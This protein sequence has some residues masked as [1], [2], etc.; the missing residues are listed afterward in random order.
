MLPLSSE[1][2]LSCSFSFLLYS[3]PCTSFFPENADPCGSIWEDLSD[4]CIPRS[5]LAPK[6]FLVWNSEQRAPI[7]VPYFLFAPSQGP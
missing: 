5:S 1:L 6:D 3:L 7:G 4:V 2:L